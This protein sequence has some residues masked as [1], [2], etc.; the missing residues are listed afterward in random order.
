VWLVQPGQAT[1]VALGAR[2]KAQDAA[3]RAG[4]TPRTVNEVWRACRDDLTA[5]EVKAIEQHL[6]NGG[7]VYI[8][9]VFT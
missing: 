7:Q 6:A 9:L 1:L 4:L 5:K 2:E 8:Q 3:G